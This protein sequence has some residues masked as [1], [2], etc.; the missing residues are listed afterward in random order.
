M[1]NTQKSCSRN[2]IA[3][4]TPYILASYVCINKIFA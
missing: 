4:N 1:Y 3:F 2:Y